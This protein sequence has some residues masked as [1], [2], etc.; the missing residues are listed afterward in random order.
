MEPQRIAF[1]CHFHI[2]QNYPICIR[3]FSYTIAFRG[4]FLSLNKAMDLFCATPP[5]PKYS[6]TLCTPTPKICRKFTYDSMCWCKCQ[7]NIH[8]MP[9]HVSVQIRALP[10]Q[11]RGGIFSDEFYKFIVEQNAGVAMLANPQGCLMCGFDPSLPPAI[12]DSRELGALLNGTSQNCLDVS[13]LCWILSWY[14]HAPPVEVNSSEIHG[15][16]VLI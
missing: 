2:L 4:H 14:R 8:L 7:E 11:I 5:P 15:M 10:S 1:K 9:N 13:V 16:D 6:N 3:W 12:Q